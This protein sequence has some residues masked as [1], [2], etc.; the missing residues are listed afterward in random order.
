MTSEGTTS[1]SIHR[2]HLWTPSPDDYR[3]YLDAFDLTEDQEKELLEALACLIQQF[4]EREDPDERSCGK[5]TESGTGRGFSANR[6]ATVEAIQEVPPEKK[7]TEH[8]E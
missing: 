3:E 2:D 8:G 6:R 1:G 4:I 7:E 5:P